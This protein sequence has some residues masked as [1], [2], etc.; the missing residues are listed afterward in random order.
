MILISNPNNRGFG[1]GNNLGMACSLSLGLRPK[2]YWLLNNDTV[3]DAGAVQNILNTL[4]EKRSI[5]GTWLMEYANPRV[6]QVIGGCHLT[7]FA[8]RA[9][10]CQ[11]AGDVETLDYVQGASMIFPVNFYK[12]TKGFDE[13]IF[14]Y[15][16]ELDLCLTARERGY[17]LDVIQ[18]QVYHKGGMSSCSV[19]QWTWVYRHKFYVMHKHFGWGFWVAANILNLLLVV[20]SPSFIPAKRTAA[21]RVLWEALLGKISLSKIPR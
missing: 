10:P 18:A 6:V 11:S 3:V 4:S 19:Q 9:I 5:W 14:M 16:E 8:K 17:D 12:E 13:A 21:R 15:F 7:R 1:A 20:L 2:F